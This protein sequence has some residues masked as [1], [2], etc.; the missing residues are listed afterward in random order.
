M[1]M[2][3]HE[4]A[5]ILLE[6]PDLPVTT[7]DCCGDHEEV[8]SAFLEESF[9]LRPGEAKPIEDEHIHLQ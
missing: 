6:G 1:T 4:L 5:K 9:Y 8:T 3:A 2:K 7:I